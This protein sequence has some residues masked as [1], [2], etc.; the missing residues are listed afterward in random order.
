MFEKRIPL[1]AA[2]SNCP[3]GVGA[4][5][6]PQWQIYKCNIGNFSSISKI[7]VGNFSGYPY[8]PPKQP[9]AEMKLSTNIA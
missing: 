1:L 6:F 9:D 8:V 7:H 4:T 3:R 2:S 5:S